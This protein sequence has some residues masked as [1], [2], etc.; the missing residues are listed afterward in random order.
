[1]PEIPSRGPQPATGFRVVFA[2]WGH[3]PLWIRKCSRFFPALISAAIHRGIAPRPAQVSDRFFGFRYFGA[4]LRPLRP[5]LRPLRRPLPLCSPSAVSNFCNCPA[6]ELRISPISSRISISASTDIEASLPS[7]ER[8]RPRGREFRP[9]FF[10]R[11]AIK[12]FSRYGRCTLRGAKV[13]CKKPVSRGYYGLAFRGV[14]R[15]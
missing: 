6:L 9:G 3:F 2:Q 8:P 7:I 15:A 12:L 11:L 13:V 14:W 5:L 1:M 10:L 4:T